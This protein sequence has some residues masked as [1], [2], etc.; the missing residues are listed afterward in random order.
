MG[1]INRDEDFCITPNTD[2]FSFVDNIMQTSS[3]QNL[4]IRDRLLAHDIFSL[5]LIDVC[6]YSLYGSGFSGFFTESRTT[7]CMTS[8][9]DLFEAVAVTL[10]MIRHQVIWQTH[11]TVWS[12]I[13]L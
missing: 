7:Q 12:L 9:G 8:S 3:Y 10:S 11:Y 4:T 13:L 1:R 6:Q 5:Y 2:I